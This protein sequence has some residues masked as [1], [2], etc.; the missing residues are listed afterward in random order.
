MG[1]S[2]SCRIEPVLEVIGEQWMLAIIHELSVGPRRALELHAAFTGLSTKTLTARLK[3]LERNRIVARKSYPQSPPRV[4]YSLTEKGLDLLPVLRVIEGVALK[5]TP[6]AELAAGAAPCRA[7][8]A[9][10]VEAAAPRPQIRPR[11]RTDITL[12]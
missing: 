11:K 4:E 1:S 8:A 10:R 5:W 7:C 9:A 12:L 2:S 6:G 3:K